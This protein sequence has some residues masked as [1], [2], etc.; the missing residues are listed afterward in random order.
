MHSCDKKKTTPSDARENDSAANRNMNA[1]ALP[2]VTDS[3]LY[4]YDGL[5]QSAGLIYFSGQYL[6]NW[7]LNT[8]RNSK[9]AVED[10][11]FNFVSLKGLL[12]GC[13][14]SRGRREVP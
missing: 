3:L 13:S 9:N 10:T 2:I 11:P 12:C 8:E 14:G 4:R 7:I 5:F 6:C 1:T